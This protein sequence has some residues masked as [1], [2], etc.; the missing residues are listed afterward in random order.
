MPAANSGLGS[1]VSVQR[2]E[3][4]KWVEGKKSKIT[5]ERI[6]KLNSIEFDWNPGQGCRTDIK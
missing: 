5:E 3:Y 1:W 6:D 2:K 4:K